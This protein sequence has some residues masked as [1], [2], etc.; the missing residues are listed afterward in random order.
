MIIFILQEQASGIEEC[1]IICWYHWW[2]RAWCPWRGIQLQSMPEQGDSCWRCWSHRQCFSSRAI[3]PRAC[4]GLDLSSFQS[5]VYV[6]LQNCYLSSRLVLPDERR[7]PWVCWLCRGVT[8]CTASS[9]LTLTH[10]IG[11]FHMNISQV[12]EEAAMFQKGHKWFQNYWLFCL[13]HHVRCCCFGANHS[14]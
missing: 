3:H 1:Y 12:S 2:S 8:I 14:I 9:W 13:W 11:G 5:S 4:Q 6:S 10:M 7:L